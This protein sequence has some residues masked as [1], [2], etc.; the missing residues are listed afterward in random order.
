MDFEAL[1]NELLA[2]LQ[3]SGAAFWGELNEDQRPIVEQAA[4]DLAEATVL[5][6][7]DAKNADLHR[8][9]ILH[10]KSTLESEATLAA[11]R[12]SARLRRALMGALTRLVEVGISAL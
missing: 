2:D 3:A 8:S 9:T 12:A 1:A 10:I 5:L 11:L 7:A 4:R 6:V